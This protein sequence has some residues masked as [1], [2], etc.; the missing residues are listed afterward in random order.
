MIVGIAADTYEIYTAENK[1]KTTTKVVGGWVG[2]WAGA[3]VGAEIGGGGL[4]LAG[5]LGPQVAT[6]E[7]VVTVPDGAVIGGIIG[8]FIGAWAG[9]E[10][11][12]TAF[13]WCFEGGM[14]MPSDSPAVPSELWRLHQ[15]LDGTWHDREGRM[16]WGPGYKG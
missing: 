5:Q 13:E 7:E 12:E 10:I 16:H 15:D 3:K 1:A 2:A 6:P 9:K 14:P 4:L 11:A 8:G